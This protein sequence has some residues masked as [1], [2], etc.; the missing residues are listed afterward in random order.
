MYLTYRVGELTNGWRHITCCQ[1]LETTVSHSIFSMKHCIYRASGEHASWRPDVTT[2]KEG[3]D[4]QKLGKGSNIQSGKFCVTVYITE[5]KNIVYACTVY[6]QDIFQLEIGDSVPNSS[7]AQQWHIILCF[8][9]NF[10]QWLSFI[11][12]LTVKV[13]R[14]GV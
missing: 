8:F 1:H 11:L 10:N 9:L 3:G 2:P 13:R 7:P 4:G 12:N 5:T 6:R 14:L